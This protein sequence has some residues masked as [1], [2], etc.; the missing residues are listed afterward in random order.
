MTYVASTGTSGSPIR[1]SAFAGCGG[2]CW[3]SGWVWYTTPGNKSSISS[4]VR[5]K[6]ISRL[7]DKRYSNF[8]KSLAND[9]ATC[10]KKTL[11]LVYFP[12]RKVIAIASSERKY[13]LIK[14]LRVIQI[15][16]TYYC[17]HIICMHFLLKC[18]NL[19]SVLRW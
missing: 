10:R 5:D 4:C 1:R 15:W 16:Q 2:Y 6:Y 13:D 3:I 9:L 18:K 19:I 17:Y 8:F 12:D 14:N 7:C 11:S